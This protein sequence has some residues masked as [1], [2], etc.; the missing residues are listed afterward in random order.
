M[1]DSA[2]LGTNGSTL[3][4]A[5]IRGTHSGIP[6]SSLGAPR[7]P[8]AAGLECI[9]PG[10]GCGCVADTVTVS[11][12]RNVDGVP[13]SDDLWSRFVTQVE[14]GFEVVE[15]EVHF[16]GDGTGSSE[17]WGDEPSRTWV[18]AMDYGRWRDTL[19]TVLTDAAKVF[20]QRAIAVT[21][22]ETEFV[23][24]GLAEA[25]RGKRVT[26]RVSLAPR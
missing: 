18:V 15:G 17:Q 3:I 12:G 9:R 25:D 13:M 16:R 2:S 24:S 26:L 23:T 22:G 7:A 21:I 4:Q 20:D 1:A 14:Y 19:R 6:G 5:R 8:S 11:I 10:L